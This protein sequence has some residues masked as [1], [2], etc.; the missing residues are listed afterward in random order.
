MTM[1]EREAGGKFKKGVVANP[2]GGM[3][4]HKVLALKKLEGL[5]GKAIARLEKL[6][7]DQ[8]GSVALGAAREILDRN[9][10]KVKQQ[11]QVDVT[12]TH[13]LHLQALE[14]LAARKKQQIID[15]Q[16]TEMQSNATLYIEGLRG[17]DVVEA[18]VVEPDNTSEA[19]T[20]PVPPEGPGAA[21][22]APTPPA[23]H[24]K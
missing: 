24:K 17:N 6:L 13:V 2:F 9:L 4:R 21:A 11:V 14:E 12:S 15:A 22:D 10:G 3:P 1:V 18:E 19:G 16:A 20:P 5:T 8:N 7:E 23:T